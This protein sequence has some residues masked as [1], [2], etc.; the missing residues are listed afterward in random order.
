MSGQTI[1]VWRTK[2]NQLYAKSAF[3]KVDIITVRDV[4]ES[5][6]D[7][8]TI[9]V[10]H[11]KVYPVCDDALFC[12][13]IMD[14]ETIRQLLLHSDAPELFDKG[15]LVEN[16]HDWGMKTKKEKQDILTKIHHIN[17]YIKN[18]V[19]T[20]I[21]FIPM[22]PTDVDMMKQY[23]TLF[24]DD[25]LPILNYGYDYREI[26]GIIARAQYCITMKHHPIIFS[27]GEGVP[28]I[29]LNYTDYY[30]HKNG[31]ALKILGI[32]EYA[33]RLDSKDCLPDFCGLFEDMVTNNVSVRDRISCALEEKK[34][35]LTKFEEDLKSIVPNH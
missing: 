22:T 3:S 30:E 27:A 29:S 13:K 19:K 14:E 6:H 23:N 35:L 33:V 18:T 16:I 17:I 20:D 32:G 2:F 26:R 9:G 34:K 1:G 12:D 31:G 7:L 4:D 11:D 5:I 28:C 24:P 25:T 21:L 10:F 15:Y 8:K